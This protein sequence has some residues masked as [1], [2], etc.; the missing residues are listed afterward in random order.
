MHGS[1]RRNAALGPI[2][3]QDRG[4]DYRHRENSGRAEAGN[5]VDGARCVYAGSRLGVSCHAAVCCCGCA[6]L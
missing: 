4:E 6:V 2:Y 1:F 3:T 5:Q